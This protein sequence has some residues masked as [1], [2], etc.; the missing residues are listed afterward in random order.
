MCTSAKVLL[1]SQAGP[2]A[3]SHYNHLEMCSL[4][5][6]P[7]PPPS[8]VQCDLGRE[9]V[10]MYMLGSATDLRRIALICYPRHDA[11]IKGDT[12]RTPL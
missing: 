1:R 10:V 7:L 9:L 5:L 6:P 2:Q 11:G 4:R 12:G 3:S 8:S